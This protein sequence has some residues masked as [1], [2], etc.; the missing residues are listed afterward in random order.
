MPTR[1]A[2]AAKSVPP[3]ERPV[4]E[5]PWYAIDP[6]WYQAH[7]VDLADLVRTRRGQLGGQV[8]ARESKGRRRATPTKTLSWEQE[9]ESM[10]EAAATAR[11]FVTS[12]TPLLEAVFRTLLAEKNRPLAIQELASLLRQRFASDDLPRDVSLPTLQRLLERQKSYGIRQ[13]TDKD[14]G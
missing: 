5:G 9:M 1:K 10:A 14:L 12:D 4:Y 6:D 3:P 2:A 13:M 8:P 7:N 11:G